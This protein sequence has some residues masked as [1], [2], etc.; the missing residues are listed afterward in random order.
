MILQVQCRVGAH[1]PARHRY[2]GYPGHGTRK[3]SFH[4]QVDGFLTTR[5]PTIST[6]GQVGATRASK[7][8]ASTCGL[9]VNGSRTN[10]AI[11]DY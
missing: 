4:H 5:V 1:Y 11:M 3:D 10:R 7:V 8:L 2:P 6:K 9:R